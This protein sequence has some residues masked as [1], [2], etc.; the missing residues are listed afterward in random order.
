TGMRL[1]EVLGLQ[2]RHVDRD[3]NSL[4]LDD[5]KTGPKTVHLNAPA[6]EVLTGITQRADCRWVIAADE[7]DDP[8][9]VWKIESASPRIRTRAVLACCRLHALRHSFA[10]VAAAGGL[11]LPI[12]GALLG[13]TQPATTARYTHLAADPLKAATESIGQRIA[14]AMAGKS[15][16]VV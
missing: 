10:S 4:R 5:S 1:G 14:A 11:S 16:Q 9:S 12:I 13:H 15:G 6:L 7:D 3:R 2:W 8:L